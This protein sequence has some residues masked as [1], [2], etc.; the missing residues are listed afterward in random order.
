LE[1]KARTLVVA[2]ACLAAC[3]SVP[4]TSPVGEWSGETV[5]ITKGAESVDVPIEKYGYLNLDLNKDSTYTLSLAVLKDVRAEHKMFGVAASTV[6]I[7]AVYKSTR[8]G[9]WQKR[10]SGEDS[11]F[12]LSSQKSRIFVQLSPDGE[13]LLLSFTDEQGRAW[14][15]RLEPKD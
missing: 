14:L 2:A 11:V 3:H 6:L 4:T 8:F 15:C 10:S 12:V 9:K 13:E 1:V 5:T 7:P